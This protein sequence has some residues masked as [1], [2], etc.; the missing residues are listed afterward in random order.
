VFSS[1][2]LSFQ[3][4]FVVQPRQNRNRDDAMAVRDSMAIRRLPGLITRRAR[5][6]VPFKLG[7]QA[8]KYQATRA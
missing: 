1:R 6:T 4:V 7:D 5:S 8:V 3:P 2:G